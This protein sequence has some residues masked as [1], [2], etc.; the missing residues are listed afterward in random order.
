MAR[1][2]GGTVTEQHEALQIVEVEGLDKFRIELD[3]EY[4]KQEAEQASGA[5]HVALLRDAASLVVPVEVVCPPVPISELA[6]LDPLVSSLREAGARGT[7]DSLLAAYGVHINA[8]LPGL[9]ADTIHRHVKAFALLQWWLVQAHAVNFSRRITPYVDLYPE[10]YLR[11][12]IEAQQPDL[13]SLFD[14]Y[15]EHNATRN[16]ALDLLPLLAH[17]D[18]A[19]VKRVVDDDRIKAR[20]TFHY[21]LPNCDIDAADW[22]LAHSWN[23]WCHVEQL[24]ANNNLLTQLGE[25][26]IKA[27]RPL[28]GVDK[29]P[30]IE[31]IEKCIQSGALA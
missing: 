5:N 10:A 2:L 30:W 1:A 20:P 16:R 15:L 28:L 12:V 18:A 19:R 8:S 3:W 9:D 25:E 7:D 13:D 6:I 4:L 22:T 31:K 14:D 17:I 29:K 27:W 24:A 23:I 26:F 21:R 11:V